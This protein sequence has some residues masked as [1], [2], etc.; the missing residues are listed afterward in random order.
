MDFLS[1]QRT[2]KV[3]SNLDL[4]DSSWFSELGFS[5]LPNR[6]SELDQSIDEVLKVSVFC[7][8]EV[9]NHVSSIRALQHPALVQC[10]AQCS[11]VTPYLL[12][13]E[14]CPLVR[15]KRK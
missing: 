1:S 9:L 5:S 6:P 7:C 10:L 3:Q 14:F 12:V 13:M 8:V 4:A 11:E 15:N 2:F